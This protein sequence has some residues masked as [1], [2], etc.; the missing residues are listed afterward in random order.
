MNCIM[1]LSD[2]L[3]G[4]S[5]LCGSPFTHRMSGLYLALQWQRRW[6]HEQASNQ[7]GTVFSCGLLLNVPAF[8]RM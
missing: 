6:S 1:R 7:G 2:G 3:V 4:G 5:L 8:I